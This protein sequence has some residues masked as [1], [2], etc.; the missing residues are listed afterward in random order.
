MHAVAVALARRDTGQ[1]DV[2]DEAVHLSQ[3]DLLLG[4]G[5]LVVLPAREEAELDA[6]GNLRE[7]GKVRP[8]AVPGRA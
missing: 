2:P 7:Q 6:L 4:D 3:L 1:V 8:P 5:F